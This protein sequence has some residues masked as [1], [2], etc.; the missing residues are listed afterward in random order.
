MRVTLSGVARGVERLVV[1]LN[2]IA[3]FDVT[4]DWIDRDTL[5]NAQMWRITLEGAPPLRLTFE[6]AGEGLERAAHS[7]NH[8]VVA[9]AM[10]VLHAIPVL[11]GRVGIQTYRDLPMMAGR[12][13]VRG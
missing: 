9:T 3:D 6:Q 4:G 12:H 10:S 2:W 11:Q 8:G 7:T 5:T 1:K 13:A